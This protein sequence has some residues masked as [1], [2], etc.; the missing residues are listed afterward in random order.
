MS[1]LSDGE[2]CHRLLVACG[3]AS[4]C[5]GAI[6]AA[7]YAA[8]LFYMRDEVGLITP[9]S[10]ARV[11]TIF[12]VFTFISLCVSVPFALIIR[13]ACLVYWAKGRRRKPVPKDQSP[14]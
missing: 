5:T 6:S 4:L 3:L 1:S 7:A 12:L 2:N 14:T 8:I 10:L 13:K 11:A 9:V